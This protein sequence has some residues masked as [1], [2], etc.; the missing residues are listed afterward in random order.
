MLAR[1]LLTSNGGNDKARALE[2]NI[3]VT[4]SH[5]RGQQQVE[6]GRW[7][8]N[9]GKRIREFQRKE[10]ED[11]MAVFKNLHYHK[12]MSETEVTTHH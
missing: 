2:H 7:G 12:L 10:R 3:P 8:R 5:P 1:N 9:L 4:A 6:K 11:E